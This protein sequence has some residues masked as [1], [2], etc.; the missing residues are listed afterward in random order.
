MKSFK[1]WR[2]FGLFVS[3]GI[4][5]DIESKVEASVIRLKSKSPIVKEEM[6]RA[7]KLNPIP[8]VSIVSLC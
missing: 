5:V 6:Q 3:N 4:S 2:R 1:V 8:P 7:R